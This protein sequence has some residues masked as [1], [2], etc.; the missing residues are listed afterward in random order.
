MKIEDIHLTLA[1]KTILTEGGQLSD[2]HIS[3]AQRL[4]QGPYPNFEGSG[5]NPS[6]W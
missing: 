6:G 3:A 4:L 2:K 5:F 1:D